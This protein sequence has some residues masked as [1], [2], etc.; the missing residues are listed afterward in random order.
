M[1]LTA[2]SYWFAIGGLTDPAKWRASVAHFLLL[3]GLSAIKGL[4]RSFDV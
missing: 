1:Q 4:T 2:A 3:Q